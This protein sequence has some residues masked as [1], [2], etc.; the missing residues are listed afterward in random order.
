MN[1]DKNASVPID[2]VSST[3][4]HEKTSCSDMNDLHDQYDPDLDV[5]RPRGM[6]NHGSANGNNTHHERDIEKVEMRRKLKEE[7]QNQGNQVQGVH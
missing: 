2:K 1:S 4:D 5:P 6:P 7:A 3:K